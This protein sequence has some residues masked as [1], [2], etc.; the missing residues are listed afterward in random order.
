MGEHINNNTHEFRSNRDMDLAF[1]ILAQMFINGFL[2]SISRATPV[3]RV[4]RREALAA[5]TTA[6]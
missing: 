5:V 3:D 4:S 1:L 6:Q 2:Q